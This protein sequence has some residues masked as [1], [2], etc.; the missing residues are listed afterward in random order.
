MASDD[1]D[2]ASKTEDP[3]AKRMED[4]RKRGDVPKSPEV[5]TWFMLGG[6]AAV[7]SLMAP[8]TSMQLMQQLR[9]IMANADSYDVGGGAFDSFAQ[10]LAMGIIGTAMVPMAVLTAIAIVA[11]LIQH[12]P[13]ISVDPIIPKFS[14]VS[15]LAGFGRLF[16]RDSVVNLVKG[17]IKL[18]I[19][20]GVM[21]Y[22]LLPER[23]RLG[24]MISY[25]PAV[26]LG[27]AEA[28]AM[29]VFWA[30]VAV[31][32][33]IAIVDFVYQRN[34]WWSKHRMTLQEVRD[35]YKQMEGDPKIKG[36][37]RQLRMARSR[38]RMMAA[39]PGATVV[40]ANPTHFAV[41]LKYDRTMQA[42]LCVAK[43]NDDLAL[44]IRALAEEHQ[45]PVVENPPLARALYAAVEV[46]RVIPTEHF[47]A[48]AQVIGYVMKL[49]RRASW[50]AGA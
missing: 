40:I 23:D 25:D 17:V 9:I 11:N 38:K 6:T 48:V 33:L 26:L 41:A 30:A 18:A 39:V 32:T 42:P 8:W 36:R 19:I 16:S 49:K 10:N 29:K 28:L 46:D 24:D 12:R 35:E 21:A 13:L 3:S 5:V 31:M 37:L 4:A 27:T 45:V 15:P 1:N 22:T 50:R 43:G 34:R 14:K 2:E 47:K 20:G 44:R 7:L